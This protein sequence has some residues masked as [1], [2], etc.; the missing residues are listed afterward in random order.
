MLRSLDEH[1][2]KLEVLIS[3]L[4]VLF[5]FCFQQVS[6]FFGYL[7]HLFTN[8]VTY[9]YRGALCGMIFGILPLGLMVNIKRKYFLSFFFLLGIVTLFYVTFKVSARPEIDA[10]S[11][12]DEALDY[13][14]EELWHGKYPY[15][16]K[17][18]LNGPIT[19]LSGSLLMALLWMAD[20]KAS[21]IKL[22]Y[23][24]CSGRPCVSGSVPPA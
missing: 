8:N 23:L 20:F 7:P 5:F 2:T 6:N 13:A 16:R 12:R 24:D 22:H 11:D 4:I 21:G 3:Y 19:A 14:L 17:T 18:Q 9:F 15:I 10:I 1:T